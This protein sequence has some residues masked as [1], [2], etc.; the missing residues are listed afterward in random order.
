MDP[1]DQTDTVADE[2]LSP[3]ATDEGTSSSDVADQEDNSL[4][5]A[6]QREFDQTYGD[7]GPADPEPEA[8]QDG[9]T[10]AEEE[11]EPEAAS[12]EDD[13]SATAEDADDDFRIPDEEFKGLPPS[14]KKRVGKLSTRLKRT[15]QELNTLKET[16]PDLEDRA[17]RFEKI[18]QF[19]QENNIDPKGIDVMFNMAAMLSKGDHAGFLAAVQPYYDHAAQATGKVIAPD[20]SERV[21]SGY[22][23]EQDAIQL[24]QAR[25][26]A[27]TSQAAAQEARQRLQREREGQQSQAAQVQVKQAIQ[28]RTEQL[29]QEDPNFA[30]KLPAIMKV[31]Q[32]ARERGA[33]FNTAEDAISM[34]N[35]AYEAI[36]PVAKPARQPVATPPRPTASTPPRGN[37]QPKTLEE[38]LA[39]GLESLPQS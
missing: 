35:A 37:A 7:A 12:G 22:L 34:L 16:V 10:Q 24:T 27:Q 17:G 21:E 15:T 8:E 28:A 5:E 31:V 36:G 39:Q 32:S 2:A 38:A 33:Q 29:Q 20:L 11:A 26:Q 18:R 13:D 23:T 3:S 25:V 4:A 1:K 9:E 6:L 14:V 30:Q 19:T